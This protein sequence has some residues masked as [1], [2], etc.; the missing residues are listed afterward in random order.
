MGTPIQMSAVVAELDQDH[1]NVARLLDLL[2]SEVLAIEVGKTPDHVLMQDIMR[3][4]TQYSGRFHH[5]KEDVIFAIILKRAP[6]ARAHI[7]DLLREH[8]SIEHCGQQ[9]DGLLQTPDINSINLRSQFVTMGFAYIQA[10]REHMRK[11]EKNVFP[12]AMQVLRENDWR[13]IDNKIEAS[14]DP[15]FG[16]MIADDYQRLYELIVDRG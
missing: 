8:V 12:L 1:A 6:A 16:E 15:L 11:E 9:F 14:D 10:L 3:Y 5:P 4:L 13:I 2:E 7:E